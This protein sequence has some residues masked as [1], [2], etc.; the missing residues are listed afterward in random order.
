LQPKFFSDGTSILIP[1]R[2][3]AAEGMQEQN[4]PWL[5]NGRTSHGEKQHDRT[6]KYPEAHV[7][8][9]PLKI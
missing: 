9:K 6:E 7:S 3:I 5:G 2:E 4:P 8:V 1:R